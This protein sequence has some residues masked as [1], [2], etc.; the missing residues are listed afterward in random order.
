[1][2]YG[3]M[4]GPRTLL[5]LAIHL[6]PR[7]RDKHL[8]RMLAWPNE[9]VASWDE[10]CMSWSMSWAPTNLIY[11]R[12]RRSIKNISFIGLSWFASIG[13]GPSTN[14]TLFRFI[15][16][17]CGIDNIPWIFL[18]S[19]NAGLSKNILRMLSIPHNIV[20]NLNNLMKIWGLWCYL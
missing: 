18:G 17:S 6:G 20:M 14:I 2:A 11:Q 10:G 9:G 12:K 19:L 16:M 8:S 3:L 1:M 7:A 4:V 15:T 5:N 13:V